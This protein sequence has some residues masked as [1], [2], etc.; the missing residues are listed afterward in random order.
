MFALQQILCPLIS[1]I[2]ISGVAISGVAIIGVAIS[3]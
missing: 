2:A 1:E 3:D